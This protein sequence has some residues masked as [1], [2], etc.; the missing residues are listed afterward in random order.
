MHYLFLEYSSRGLMDP[1]PLFGQQEFSEDLGRELGT[2]TYHLTEGCLD[3][4]IEFEL[5]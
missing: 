4:Y 1:D 5:W 3:I 2:K